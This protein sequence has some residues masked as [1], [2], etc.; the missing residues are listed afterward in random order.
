MRDFRVSSLG[1][2]WQRH[3]CVTT[4]QLLLHVRARA[5]AGMALKLGQQLVGL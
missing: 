2:V 1:T 4:L 3:V 5:A